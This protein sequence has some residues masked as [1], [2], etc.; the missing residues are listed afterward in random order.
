MP[1][2]RIEPHLLVEYIV[3]IDELCLPGFDDRKNAVNVIRI[4]DES[5]CLV[6]L[7]PVIPL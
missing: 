6:M 5:L 2:R 1:W 7:P 4:I 3:A